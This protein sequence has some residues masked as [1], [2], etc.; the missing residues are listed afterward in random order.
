MTRVL[1]LITGQPSRLPEEAEFGSRLLDWADEGRHSRHRRI[2]LL[3]VVF[4]ALAD[5]IG[6]AVFWLIVI[7]AVP[8]PNVFTGA[9]AWLTFGVVPAYIVISMAAGSIWVKRTLVAAVDWSV[10]GRPPTSADQRNTFRAPWDLARIHILLWGF[11][12]AILGTLYGL[13]DPNFIPK[14]LFS[15]VLIGVV[16]T[17]NAYLITELVIRPAAAQAIAAG[18]PPGWLA[19]G[20]MGRIMTVWILGSG[21]PVFGIVLSSAVSLRLQLETRHQFA[22][23]Q[24][25]LASVVLVFGFTLMWIVA[26]I[27]ATPVRVVRTALQR[28]EQGDLDTNLVVF[29]GTEVGELQHGFNSMVEGLRERERVRDL[30]GRHVGRMVAANAEQHRIEL[31][32]QERHVAVLF[33]D[34]EGSTKLAATHPP[35]EVVELLNRFFAVIVDEVYRQHGSVNKFIGDAILAVFGAPTPLKRC[36]G[37]ALAAARAISRRLRE[38]VPECTAGLGVAAGTVVAGN[39]GARE[40]F[41]YTVIGDPVNEAARLSDLAKQT[42]GLLLAS[43]TTVNAAS[44]LQRRHWQLGDEVVLRGR[45]TTTRLAA[46]VIPGE[47]SA[48]ATA[49]NLLGRRLGQIIGGPRR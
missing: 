31:G 33:V 28:V 40:R 43:E 2:R 19:T 25:I 29:D 14:I 21:V 27:T 3:I 18:H 49:L 36:E 17:T 48:P 10:A 20:V 11:G 15:I 32:G 4:V 16:A 5:L 35:M 34:L 45:P 24:L 42:P 26:W 13:S 23:G 37:N 39:I 22:I 47:Q 46:P 41:E 38:E 7:V 1:E 8:E 12:A 6:V 30:F 9:P 44:D